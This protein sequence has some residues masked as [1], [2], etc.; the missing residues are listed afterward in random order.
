[1]LKEFREIRTKLMAKNMYQT[2]YMNYVKS[3][4]AF[5]CLVPFFLD[6]FFAIVQSVYAT[7]NR[8]ILKKTQKNK[9][10]NLAIVHFTIFYFAIYFALNYDSWM[11][12]ILS[13][14]C[15]GK[16]F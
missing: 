10:K 2:N 7:K 11:G 3:G 13:S 15:L 14:C 8:N 5:V 6:P 12:V 1:M 9:K 16:L 4:K